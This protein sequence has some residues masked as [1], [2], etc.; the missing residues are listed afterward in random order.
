MSEIGTLTQ[1]ENSTIRKKLNTNIIDSA[2]VRLY[3]SKSNK[4]WEY[5]GIIGAAVL[6]TSNG[7]VR[8]LKIVELVGYEIMFEQELYVGMEYQE[9]NKY[10]HAFEG[11]EF[12][13]G[14]SFANL[15]EAKNFQD[16]IKK[17]IPKK[18]KKKKKG[19]MRSF[20]SKFSKNSSDD[21]DVQ[22]EIIISRPT[23]FKHEGHIGWDPETG[24]SL[25]NIPEAWSSLFK[26]AGIKKSELNN[27]ET[28]KFIIEFVV[29]NLEKS[30]D[31]EKK[32]NNS[33]KTTNSKAPPPPKIGGGGPPLLGVPPPN[34]SVGGVPKQNNVPERTNLMDSIRNFSGGLK[35][36]EEED[37]NENQ[38]TALPDISRLGVEQERSLADALAEAMG[39]RRG[40][41]NVFSED[42]EPESDSE[43]SD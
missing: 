35:N 31:G 4:E 34:L 14:L 16:E 1:E 22:N 20:K 29:E 8:H 36:V 26:S 5:T 42:E 39:Q 30:T 25:K 15:H 2:V 38:S 6:V 7:Q 41:I 9:L 37:P 27:P 40:A 3:K 10:V 13:Y 12:V 21:E 23:D 18:K 28:A 19:F 43:W 11:D 24:F 17:I 32:K 33:S